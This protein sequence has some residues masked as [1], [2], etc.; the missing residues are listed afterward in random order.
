MIDDGCLR[1]DPTG[2]NIVV[3]CSFLIRERHGRHRDFIRRDL[4]SK[5]MP[6]K[7]HH[8]YAGVWMSLVEGI[9]CLG[10]LPGRMWTDTILRYDEDVSRLLVD[11]H[12]AVRIVLGG[13]HGMV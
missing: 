3:D 5:D 6:W 11:Q 1:A 12:R 4:N 2:S 13:A 9:D 10:S 7:G 8:I